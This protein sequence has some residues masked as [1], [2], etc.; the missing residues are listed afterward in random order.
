MPFE[1]GLAVA[2]ERMSRKG[3]YIW[4]VFES[5]RR[6]VHKSLSDVGGTDE[7]IHGGRVSGVL[8][9]LGNALVR[10]QSAPTV[11]QMSSIYRELREG[12][13]KVQARAGA[14]SLFEARVFK[15]LVVP[16][17]MS[18]GKHVR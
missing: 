16:A 6:R 15:E 9:E 18:A 8:R 11:Q 5:T 2:S 4:F 3:T 12:A 1:L 10:R 14:K 7:Y 17:G 13:R